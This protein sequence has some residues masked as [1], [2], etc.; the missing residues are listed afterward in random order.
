LPVGWQAL[1]VG[2]LAGSVGLAEIV[3]RYRSNPGYTLRHSSAA[4]LYVLLNA[5]AGVVA[6]FVIRAFG[7]TFGQT[8]HVDLWRILVASFGA[9]AFFRS[10]LFVTKI[11]DANVGVGPSLV[12]SALLDAFDREVDR[13]S[14]AEIAQVTK[15]DTLAGLDPNTVMWALPV[16]CLALMQN[17]PPGD[18][19]LLGTELI[20]TRS[21]DT[22]SPQAKMQAV[23]IQLAKYLGA[24]LVKDVLVNGRAIFVAA[25]PPSPPPPA[26]AAPAA[27][28]LEEARKLGEA[29]KPEAGS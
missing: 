5:G 15:A 4:W 20:K 7:W 29:A 24:E 21:D 2:V 11:G 28:V 8:S 1:I 19:A 26:T 18:Q 14:A 16:L 12:L 25:P 9:I 27:A 13:T 23:V 22:L 10:S 6:L 17:F 3:S